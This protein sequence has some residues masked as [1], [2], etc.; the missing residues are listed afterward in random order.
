MLNVRDRDD[1]LSISNR[2]RLL[3]IHNLKLNTT[4]SKIIDFYCDITYI[5]KYINFKI[6][7]IDI[8]PKG[9]YNYIITADGEEIDRGILKIY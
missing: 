4:S 5:D 3:T 6:K 1:I 8:L 9:S 2:N 7:D